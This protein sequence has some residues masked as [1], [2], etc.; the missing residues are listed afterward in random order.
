MRSN[1]AT[2]GTVTEDFPSI[3]NRTRI[4]TVSTVHREWGAVWRQ[5]SYVPA[6]RLNGEWLRKAGFAPGQ[7]VQVT[8]GV[9]TIV[10][11]VLRLP[12]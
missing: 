7:K 6:L 10:I 9:G 1:V 3:S 12:R 2:A 8:L 11:A 5:H 4:L